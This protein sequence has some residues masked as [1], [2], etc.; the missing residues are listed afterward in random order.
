MRLRHLLIAGVITAMALTPAAASGDVGGDPSG[1]VGPGG[2][3]P[4]TAED[5]ELVGHDPLFGR[6]MNSA[7]TI[8][9]HYV[10]VGNRTD[11]SSTCGIGDPRRE[12]DPDSC[13]H[14]HPGVL[15]VDVADP[16]DPQV[17]GEIGPPLEGNDGETSRELR[18]W[19][20]KDLLMVMNFTCSAFLH[21]CSGTSVTPEI[22]FYDL[23][24][25]VDPTLISAYQPTSQ[26]G[27]VRTPHEMFLWI[28]P[29]DPDRA[30]LW[31][32]VPTISL[33]PER[34]NMMIVDISDVP[35][36]GDVTLVAE[37]NWNA[38]Y[39][40]TDDPDYGPPDCAV[41][42]CNLALHSMTPSVDGTRTYLA[43]LSG[44]FLV[45]DTTAV[46]DGALGAGEVLSLND[47][48]L[49]PPENRPTW[50]NPNPAH[51]A[52]PLPG[53]PF[54]LVTDE[55]YGTFTLPSFGCP[56]GWSRLINV[57]Q[58]A[59]PHIVGEYKITENTEAFCDTL[60]PDSPTNQFTSFASH[61]PTLLRNLA[62]ISWH[63]GGLQAIDISDPGQPVQAGWFSPEPL[64]SVATEDP[65]LSRG[66]NKVVMWSFPIVR[67]GL[68]YVTDIRNGL[69]ILRY[70]GTQS[71]RVDAIDFLDGA[72]N[73]G[74]A[75]RID[76]SAR[77][78]AR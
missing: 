50:E 13:P 44:H 48:L 21:A 11:G 77:P 71:Q 65:A 30:L 69:Y 54:A 7:L 67:D 70:T 41:Y 68:I 61:N 20:D 14:E 63:S 53:R 57:A 17:V 16:S 5:F 29:G 28:D 46:A 43:Y 39:P 6:G 42:D 19:P 72:S 25:P 35:D 62:F 45:L 3:T 75:V 49:T 52:V 55:V 47:D 31:L 64:A 2:G 26:N 12:E 76:Q 34:P 60:A 51:S 40:G 1:G 36:G 15:V 38:L 10:Y 56:W 23:S 33:D 22:R 74:D 66:P 78:T 37:G 73:L 4:A 59:R 18:V 24:D 9:E 27:Q 58:P 8:Y 32:S